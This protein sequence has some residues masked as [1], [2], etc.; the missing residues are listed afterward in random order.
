MP[1]INQPE[2]LFGINDCHKPK[3]NTK[4]NY[5]FNKPAAAK[6][7]AAAAAATRK[8]F[9][10]NKK[11]NINN[12]ILFPS[13][14]GQTKIGAEKAPAFLANYIRRK[15][16]KIKTVPDTGDLYKNLNQLYQANDSMT[17]KRINVG[18]DHSMSIA[19]IAYTINH[20]PNAKVIYF[21]AHGDINTYKS[22]KSKHY[23]GMPL[24]F[25][26]KLNRDKRFGFIKNKLDFAD[27]LYI[28]S[29]CWDRFEV[30]QV[31]KHNIKF[32]EPDDINKHFAESMRKI[33]E[34]VGDS[35]VHI[36]FDVDSIDPK[37]IPSTGTAVKNGV[38]L[39]NAIKI[40]ANVSKNIVNM[41][42]T[43]L[44]M[45]V[46]SKQDGKKSGMNTVKLFKAFL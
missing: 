22:S 26:T 40:L 25:V 4:K 43:E 19:T 38:E 1:T 13:S 31:Y 28:G 3:K 33:K 29:R 12:F 23:H 9:K 10:L 42:I 35:P 8:I 20:Y 5:A 37:Y 18:G 39:N 11:P 24:S 21:D 41:D 32:L 2:S 27:I 16:R 6:S 15:Q 46:G 45:E 44:N 17:G 34:F 36:S 14:L 7:T 30:N